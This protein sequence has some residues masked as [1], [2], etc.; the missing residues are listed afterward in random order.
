[1]T[2]HYLSWEDLARHEVEGQDYLIE[3]RQSNPGILI[4]APHGGK[5]E[6]FTNQIADELAG[7]K[8]SYYAFKGIKAHGNSHLHLTSHRFD[9]PT[10]LKAVAEAEYVLTI[11]GEKSPNEQFI[12]IGGLDR[13]LREEFKHNLSTAGFNFRTKTKLEGISPLNICNRGRRHR[14][15]QFELSYGLRRALVEDLA[16]R[17]IFCDILQSILVRTAAQKP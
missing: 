6:L 11:H 17:Q 1:M 10:A 3:W 9:E 8:F 14:G 16:R 5:I 4:M 7:N 2:D 13:E 12:I 15:V